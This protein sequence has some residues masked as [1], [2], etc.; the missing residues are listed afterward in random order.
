MDDVVLAMDGVELA[1]PEDLTARFRAPVAG[2]HDAPVRRVDTVF[3]VVTPGARTSPTR[4]VSEAFVL[5]PGACAAGTPTAR[6]S[7]LARRTAGRPPRGGSASPLDGSG[8]ERSRPRPASHRAR[9]GNRPIRATATG[10][11]SWR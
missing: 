11:A 9:R 2:S 4:P 6:S 3:E 1:V 8:R 7:S 5:D 10:S